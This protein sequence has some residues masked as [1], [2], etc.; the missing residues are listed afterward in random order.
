MA[1]KNEK[2]LKPLKDICLRIVA[3]P[4]ECSTLM[5]QLSEYAAKGA[6]YEHHVFAMTLQ[7][8]TNNPDLPSKAL[9]DIFKMLKQMLNDGSNN[10]D[11]VITVLYNFM[12]QN[13]V[14]SNISFTAI[15]IQI[16]HILF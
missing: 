1:D 2:F 5:K 15:N 14:S 16:D 11:S 12:L 8:I 3:E 9:K 4:E 13:K 10:K 7:T 6:F